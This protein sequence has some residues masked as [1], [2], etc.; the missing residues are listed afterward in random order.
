MI[1]HWEDLLVCIASPKK[2]LGMRNEGALRLFKECE[3]HNDEVREKALVELDAVDR[4]T[5]A[6][7]DLLQQV[8]MNRWLETRGWSC[9]ASQ[10]SLSALRVTAE[11]RG[12]GG[13]RP[14]MQVHLQ[15]GE[16][17]QQ[18]QV[19]FITRNRRDLR[20]SHCW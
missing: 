6:L 9:N 8:R 3:L 16:R 12:Q 2:R 15:P 7:E 19:P 5:R 13:G 11:A 18:H 10:C 1:K 14:Y 20:A 4:L 17:Q